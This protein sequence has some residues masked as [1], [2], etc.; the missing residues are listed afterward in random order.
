MTTT[1]IE[2]AEMI[3]G[4]LYSDG[5]HNECPEPIR[6]AFLRMLTHTFL[7]MRNN[8]HPQFHAAVADHLHNVPDLLNN[9]HVQQLGWYRSP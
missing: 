4:S 9:F 6:K 7:G 8:I 3:P 1:E 5:Y 2:T